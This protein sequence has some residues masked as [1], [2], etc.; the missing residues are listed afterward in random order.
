MKKIITMALALS[1]VVGFAQTGRVGINTETPSATMNIKSKNDSQTPKNLELE[2]E[3]GAKI[4]TVLNHGN[5]GIN[6]ENPFYN[7]DVEGHTRSIHFYS[8]SPYSNTVYHPAMINLSSKGG[9]VKNP[10]FVEKDNV[11]G[12]FLARDAKSSF[13]A[14]KAGSGAYG[15]SEIYAYATENFTET[16]KGSNLVFRTTA[17]GTNV[18]DVRMVIEDDG[19]L[20]LIARAIS[21]GETC[22][23]GSISYGSDGEFYACKGSTWKQVQLVD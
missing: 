2:N 1:S 5:V 9:S 7:L 18:S 14:G 21:K 6:N 11:L 10:I 17:K 13:T 22:K 19:S 20:R 8:F 3:A 16:A 4:V 23:D 12:A 15:G